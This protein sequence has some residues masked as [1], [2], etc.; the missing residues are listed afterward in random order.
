MTS[1]LVTRS[2]AAAGGQ[3]ALG[4]AEELEDLRVAG[5]DLGGVDTERSSLV[6]LISRR[7]R[8]LL[9]RDRTRCGKVPVG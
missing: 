4:A 6:T 3:S 5:A 1:K 7:A 2:R 8:R 9:A